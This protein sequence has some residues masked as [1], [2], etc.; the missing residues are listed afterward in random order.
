VPS[1]SVAAD[2]CVEAFDAKAESLPSRWQL[3]ERII[4]ALKKNRSDWRT[5]MQLAAYEQALDSLPTS[6][7]TD[8]AEGLTQPQYSEPKSR[9][10]PMILIRKMIRPRTHILTERLREP[11]L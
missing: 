9:F 8:L 4:N 5:L 1:P 7:W 10:H 3:T 2:N 6:I 11:R